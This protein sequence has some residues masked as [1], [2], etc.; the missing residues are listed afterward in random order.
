MLLKEFIKDYKMIYPKFKK[1]LEMKLM[2][3][4]KLIKM[5]LNNKN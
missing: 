1:P 5:Y 3:E 4:M 2:K